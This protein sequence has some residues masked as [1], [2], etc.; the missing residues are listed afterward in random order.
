SVFQGSIT[1][2]AGGLG[3]ALVPATTTLGSHVVTFLGTNG[4]VA[5]A[6]LYVTTPTGPTNTPTL[7]P[8]LSFTP[9]R[10]PTITLTPTIVN[11]C[12]PIS[13]S[14]DNNDASQIGRM[15]R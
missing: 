11:S 14:I 3:A 10:T 13:G 9:T 5:Q 1:T 7:T 4:Q 12:A 15:T 6:P 2:T 8:L